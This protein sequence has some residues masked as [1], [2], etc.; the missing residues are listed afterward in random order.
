VLREHEL[1]VGGDVEDAAAALRELRLDA[2][3]LLDPGSQTDRPRQ[4]VSGHAVRDDD[5]H[6]GIVSP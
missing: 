1:A 2:Q 4:V 3:L 5:L 6:G